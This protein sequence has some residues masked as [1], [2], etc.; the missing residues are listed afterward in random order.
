MKRGFVFFIYFILYS[1]K[2]EDEREGSSSGEGHG[3][4]RA[5]RGQTQ[6]HCGHADARQTT[7]LQVNG[8]VKNKFFPPGFTSDTGFYL[9]S[10]AILTTVFC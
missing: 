6:K 3:R 8:V 7:D 10:A 9:V 2:R 4:P 5:R 1:K